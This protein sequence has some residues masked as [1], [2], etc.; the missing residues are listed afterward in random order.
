MFFSIKYSFLEQDVLIFHQ[1]YCMKFVA[2]AVAIKLFF[3]FHLP[4]D[5]VPKRFIHRSHLFLICSSGRDTVISQIHM[6]LLCELVLS[7]TKA[8]A[9]ECISITN[10]VQISFASL[11]ECT[12]TYS[13]D[14]IVYYHPL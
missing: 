9:L 5:N 14:L 13:S 7:I 11:S 6:A 4:L 1:F 2:N 3:A 12:S 10:I 8:H